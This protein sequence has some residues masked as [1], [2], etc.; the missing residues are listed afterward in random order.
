MHSPIAALL[1]ANWRRTRWLIAA[2][3]LLFFVIVL[4]M[5]IQNA[6]YGV[7]DVSHAAGAAMVT[8]V[9]LL[10]VTLLFAHCNPDN[11]RFG[12][13]QDLY[14]LPFGTLGLAA[15]QFAYGVIVMGLA[16][17]PM[18]AVTAV[19]ASGNRME[20]A[21]IVV[22]VPPACMLLMAALYAV[23]WTLGRI[24]GALVVACPILVVV[25]LMIVEPQVPWW[26]DDP[27][28][29]TSLAL[30]AF[31]TCAVIAVTGVAIDRAGRLGRSRDAIGQITG[32][33]L[34]K[35]L[36][37]PSA[38]WAQVWFEWRRGAW[39]LP[40]L[41]FV[42]YATIL[43]AWCANKY[44]G[45]RS[46]DRESFT[47]VAI[48][49]GLQ[50]PLIAAL[51]IGAI[52][53]FIEWREKRSAT[54]RFVFTHPIQTRRIAHARLIATGL[55]VALA[56]ALV[57]GIPLIVGGVQSVV[58]HYSP[59]ELPIPFLIAAGIV[60]ILT[61][62]TL[63]QLTL[64]LIFY[65]FVSALLGFGASYF[66]E[67]RALQEFIMLGI[68]PA[69]VMISS[70]WWLVYRA[71]RMGFFGNRTVL[72]SVFAWLL[73]SLAALRYSSP[74]NSDLMGLNVLGSV[75]VALLPLIPLVIGAQLVHWQ[76]HA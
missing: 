2:S 22:C 33:S 61:V 74:Q 50:A 66:V 21:L 8:A 55:S 49:T 20:S 62:W 35:G 38:G 51:V 59:W 39:W 73:F 44:F 25:L 76:R 70:F 67:D 5:L 3:L 16:S 26:V 56:E 9:L 45:G 13:A 15:F 6:L 65:Y 47:Q 71:R 31:F 10:A 19:A 32:P 23:S 4:A 34:L 24:N 64:P 12:F 57:L 75:Y 17:L 58:R 30:A 72:A 48:F 36:R 18:A 60:H 11:I 1:W 54:A 69:A 43:A 7:G 41:S 46:P 40:A 27:L 42:M 14:T 63:T 53:T 52:R 37:F 28:V 29:L 68:T